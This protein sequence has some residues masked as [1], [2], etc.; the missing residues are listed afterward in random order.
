VDSLF[1]DLPCKCRQLLCYPSV[2]DA[3]EI[4]NY[5]ESC[6]VCLFKLNCEIWDQMICLILTS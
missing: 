5:E 2:A 4:Q 3:D 6:I 1:K